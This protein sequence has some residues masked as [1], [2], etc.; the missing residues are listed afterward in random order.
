MKAAPHPDEAARL[1]ALRRYD[2]LD[3]PR[4]SDFD[5]VV[6]LAARV[7]GAPISVINLIDADRQWFKAEVGLGVRE[8]P[9]DTSI[10][11]HVILEGDFVEIPDTLAD[12]RMRDNPLCLAD[13][14]LRFYAGAVLRTGDGQPIGTLCVLDNVPRQLD[15]LQ[16]QALRVLAAQVMAR[17]DLHAAL[18][19]ETMLRKEIDH[20]VKN[21]LQM[22]AAFAQLQRRQLAGDA[23]A[24]LR[25]VEQQ[26]GTVALLHDLLSHADGDQRIDL[27]EYFERLTDALARMLPAAIRITSRFDPLDLGPT[28]VAALG[29]VVNELVTNALKHS[30][31]IGGAGTIVLTGQREGGMYRLMCEDHGK[32]PDEATLP[33]NGLGLR[34]MTAAV[35]QVAGVLESGPT[36]GG[37]RS[38]VTFPIH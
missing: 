11:A 33:G 3:T 17:L 14:G 31:G 12:Q 34:I 7:C 30:Y 29:S 27:A 26:V 6:A 8:T 13:P 15:D 19:R 32:G 35:R 4:E 9:L 22:V 21:S 10:C 28:M 18:M 36:S 24:A 25:A 37:Y 23:D 2:I 20:R 1:V 5:D 38:V 16:R